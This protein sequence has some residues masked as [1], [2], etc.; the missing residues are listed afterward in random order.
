MKEMAKATDKQLAKLLR[1]KF[2]QEHKLSHARDFA[3][4]QAGQRQV[5]SDRQWVW[6]GSWEEAYYSLD[7]K[8]VEAVAK[9]EQEFTVLRS[10]VARIKNLN[11][12]YATHRWSRFYLV[13]AGHIHSSMECHSCYP[14]TQYAWLPELS[15]DTEAE[16]VAAEGEI[17]CTFCFPSAPVAWTEGIGRRTKEER[18]AKAAEKA[19]RLAAKAAK[20]LS[21][22]GSVVEISAP[23]SE[24]SHYSRWKEFKT[25][26]AAELWLVEAYTHQNRDI[27][28]EE[29]R[30]VFSAPDAYSPENV[31]K[32]VGMVAAKVGKPVEEVEAALVKKALAKV[33]KA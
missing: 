23:A 5:Y 15:G 20:S 10:I 11:T 31:D 9:Y 14:D 29:R 21:L 24:T 2:S 26:R 30:W 19:A 18:D 28:P 17:L 27:A 3:R 1:D 33:N 22:D 32:V 12:I 6:N 25:L 4:Y 8:V 13:P 16:A 7:P